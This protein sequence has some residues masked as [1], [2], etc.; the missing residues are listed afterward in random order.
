MLDGDEPRSVK[1][2][3]AHLPIDDPWRRIVEG[4]NFLKFPPRSLTDPEVNFY[5]A[6]VHQLGESLDEK[7][8][9][10]N[11][12]VDAF[13]K[14]QVMRLYFISQSGIAR[15]M[16]P[17]SGRT[18]E[19]LNE[20]GAEIANAVLRLL[21]NQEQPW[22]QLSDDQAAKIYFE[23]LEMSGA[24]CGLRATDPMLAIADRRILTP[25]VLMIIDHV[26]GQLGGFA[27]AHPAV[28]AYSTLLFGSLWRQSPFRARLVEL[29]TP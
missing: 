24:H 16:V 10:P 13:V 18:E 7:D 20:D 29:A 9:V 22:S 4:P 23:I 21:A 14:A 8:W 28:A 19:D 17:L 3:V 5:D 25:G 11:K 26:N 27:G 6:Y 15:D 1:M 12:E 2:Q